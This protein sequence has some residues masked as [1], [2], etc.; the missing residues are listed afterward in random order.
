[1]GL[2]LVLVVACDTGR[3]ARPTS[4]TGSETLDAARGAERG[5]NGPRDYS[6]AAAI[7]ASLCQDGRGSLDACYSLLDAMITSVG[8]AHNQVKAR[9]L[10]KTLCSRGDSVS[11]VVMIMEQPAVE[12][13]DREAKG[14][15]YDAQLAKL[16]AACTKGDGRACEM[17]VI[18]HGGDGGTAQE[19]RRELYVRACQLGRIDA[20]SRLTYDL[21]SCEEADDPAVCEQKLLAAWSV[22]SPSSHAAALTLIRACEQGDALAC[23]HVPSKRIPLKARCDAHDFEA[24]GELG[25]LGDAAAGAQAKQ[26]KVDAN[27]QIAQRLGALEAK[28]GTLP[29]T[30][31]VD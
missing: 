2:F 31:K 17:L 4:N 5:I 8:V 6:R 29:P 1:V 27:C 11:C 23:V 15:E 7:Y 26:N 30:A 20:C 22:K 18:N 13:A 25:C 16:E 10:M 14:R 19:A 9:G 21:E 12:S 28:R 24:C 3:S